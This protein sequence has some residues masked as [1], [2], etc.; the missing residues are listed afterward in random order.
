VTRRINLV[1]IT[2]E[3]LDAT[4]SHQ[5]ALRQI[6]LERL[7]NLASTRTPEEKAEIASHLTE[8]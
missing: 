8:E 6:R 5:E 4:V 1:I 2:S 7:A 3:I